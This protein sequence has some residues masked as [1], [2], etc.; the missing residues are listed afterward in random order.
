[1][2]MRRARRHLLPRLDV[3]FV[4]FNKPEKQA[5]K[6]ELMHMFKHF[7]KLKK[8]GPKKVPCNPNRVIELHINPGSCCTDCAHHLK[9]GRQHSVLLGSNPTRFSDLPGTEGSPTLHGESCVLPGKREN[10]AGLWTWF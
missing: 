9:H 6:E 5:E 1:M 7:S 8:T 3:H 10:L 4:D 2:L